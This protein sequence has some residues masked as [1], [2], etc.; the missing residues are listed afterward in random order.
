M[1][2]QG[3]GIS[4]EISATNEKLSRVLEQS[5]A[6]LQGFTTSAKGGGDSVDAAFTKMQASIAK[7]TG[8]LDKINDV[9]TK[10]YNDLIAKLEQAKAARQAAWNTGDA[11]AFALE[12]INVKNLE[13][14]VGQWQKVGQAINERYDELAQ[15]KTKTEEIYNSTKK[16]EQPIGT[17]RT[18]LRNA[19][20]ELIKMEQSGQRGTQ[21]Y[22]NQRKKVVQLTQAMASAN[23]QAKNLS[24]PNRNFQAV[25]G[26][27]TLMTSGY[28]AVT[29]AMGL[30]AGENEN[31]QR[32]M[33]KVQS[34][35]SI[36]MALQTAYTQL[37]KN[38]A[39]Q[40]VI[41]AKAKEAL[42]VANTR[43]AAAL[44]ISTAAAQALTATLTFGL[45]LAIAAIIALITK[46]QAESAKAK[47]AQDEFNTKVSEA[48]GKPLAAY[49]VLQAQWLSLTES[50]EEKE[51][52]V[53]SNAEKFQEL[54][55]NVYSA[56]DAEDVLVKNAQNFVNA[57]ILKAKALAAQ[58]LASEKY[59]E[60]L[61]KQAEIEAMPQ[62][63]TRTVTDRAHGETYDV[64]TENKERKKAEEELKTMEAEAR[65]LVEKALQFSQEEQALLERLGQVTQ[66]TVAGSV[67]A[68]E[69]EL[70]RLQNLYRR[71]AT[72]TER[73]NL[74][75]QIEAQQ[76]VVDSMSLKG[77]T[78]G[79][80]GG[81][82]GRS[83]GRTT[84]TKSND[85]EDPFTKLLENRKKAY[86]EYNKWIS[87][88]DATVRAAA[89]TEFASILAD[90]NSYLEY[91]ERQRALIE[92]KTTKTATDIQHL[93]QLNEEIANTARQTALEDFTTALQ[94]AVNEATTL[95]EKLA[96]ISQQREK[97]SGEPGTELNGQKN[98]QLNE[99]E[100]KLTTEALQKANELVNAYRESTNKALAEEQE[101]Q[102]KRQAIELAIEKTSNE[103]QKRELQKALEYLDLMHQAGIS[104]FEELEQLYSEGAN[105][106]Q[107]YEAKRLS[108]VEKY[109]KQI[110]AARIKGDE[111]TA[112][113]LENARDV[114]LIKASQEYTTF[115]SDV[116]KM[117]VAAF[118][119]VKQKLT[120]MAKQFLAQ[121]KITVEQYKQ[122]MAEINAQTNQMYSQSTAGTQTLFGNSKTG[123]WFNMLFGEGD[124]N[125][126]LQDFS[127][128]FNGAKTD[129]SGIASSMGSTE[130][131]AS[132]AAGQMGSAASGAA[133][134][135]AVVDQI[136]KAVYQ[137][138]SAITD[139]LEA[140]S[141]Y[142]DSI[143]NEDSASTL[144]NIASVMGTIN[145]GAYSAWN[146]LKSGNVMGTVS[147]I[148][149]TPFKVL[150]SL[151][152]IH[153]Q[154]YEKRIQA[155]QRAVQKLANAYNQL[156]HEI[157]NALGED[158]Y[159]LQNKSIQNLR[160]QN[161]EIEQMIYNEQKKKKTDNDKIT[162]WEEQI[163]ENKRTIED[164]ITEISESITQTSGTELAS[165]ISDALVG[166]F[167]DGSTDASKKI[168]E[169]I[170]DAL[171]NAV[172]NALKLQLLEKPLAAAVAQLQKDMGFDEEG[173]GTFDGLTEEEQARFRSAVQKASANFQTAMSA[174]KELF[175]ELDD[176]DPTTLSGAIKGASQES[177]DMLAGQ[178]NAVRMN[179]VTALGLFR[180][181][182]QH[183]VSMDNQL[184]TIGAR[185]Q[186][187][188]NKLTTPSDDG[189]RGQG[190][191]N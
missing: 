41:V 54:G 92:E 117:T 110:S 188:V 146:N 155:H 88:E 163:A 114:E 164:L 93:R 121:G 1:N 16:S 51:K 120:A 85:N 137:T 10:T 109:E 50:M 66:Q 156:S 77:T 145:D 78:G 116:S 90:G 20:E 89:S 177:I 99:V 38:S 171:G 135:L 181:Q 94:Q 133:S 167:E 175:E 165:S 8:E 5:K 138:L 73:A 56:K 45:S 64:T 55:L 189:L 107:D 103:T 131:S 143:G 11:H 179:Q 106:L 12:R 53:Q 31:L 35:M 141:E 104:T 132:G 32:I 17:I 22:E 7:T 186:T 187:I 68:A 176:T 75:K 74:K 36:T 144:S 40:L 43:L 58:N 80:S 136:V 159:G 184:A 27:L 69:Q 23:K 19:R 119:G 178:C 48:A 4:F 128:I 139:C 174:Y 18:Q 70:A 34:L 82:G 113:S 52:W 151:N 183:V 142:E 79:G 62:T 100:Q 102:A 29:G 124:F 108:I 180:E 67:E 28:Q 157:D 122:L 168:E 148:I 39:F 21:A 182:L 126:K 81:N 3:G 185:L 49:A 84:T 173:N 71:A 118:E 172:T 24:N 44:G 42:A 158:S 123:G 13:K 161:A 57:C 125:S 72:S 166:V 63:V 129:M 46:M 160:Q 9:W 95:S 112:K 190:L 154:K 170:K 59:A 25:I 33:T 152:K 147:D 191:I 61:K 86:S 115:F 134:T 111:Q 87:S 101:Y 98:D 2:V 130:S 37:N 150:T 65:G 6:L 83:G 105:S 60:I 47:K 97:L 14:Q 96:V 149:S 140:I 162:D 76:K 26:G 153:D 30:F 15:V 91:L 127:K 169:V